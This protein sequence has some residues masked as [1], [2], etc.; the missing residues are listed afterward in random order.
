[1]I[2]DQCLNAE[3]QQLMLT[4]LFSALFVEENRQMET[5]H[6][7][8]DTQNYEMPKTKEEVDTLEIFEP[9]HDVAHFRAGPYFRRQRHQIRTPKICSSAKQ[10]KTPKPTVS[11]SWEL[12]MFHM[13]FRR[14]FMNELRTKNAG[15]PEMLKTNKG[16]EFEAS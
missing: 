1:M 12:V 15:S 8:V 14:P 9:K 2:I 6:S 5:K 7:L 4:L 10:E 11:A 16:R 3:R 13:R